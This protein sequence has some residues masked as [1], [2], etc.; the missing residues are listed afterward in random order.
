MKNRGFIM[1]KTN[2]LLPLNVLPEAMKTKTLSVIYFLIGFLFIFIGDHGSFLTGFILKALIIPV[3]MIIFLVNI[4]PLSFKLHKLMLAG[5]FFS[6]A[7]DIVLEVPGSFADLFIP[8]L[9]CFLLAHVMYMLVFFMTP[10]KNSIFSSRKYLLIPVLI[11]G[12]AL[13][14]FLY[15]DLAAMK[16]P[17]IL[18]AVVIQQI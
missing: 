5:L 2:S 15:N 1:L 11:Y 9:V 3:L 4:R 8:G 14:I 12:T 7:G 16:L 10:G 17:V 18:Y 6:W 13:I